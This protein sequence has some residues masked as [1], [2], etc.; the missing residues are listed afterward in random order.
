M[1]IL[2]LGLS[3][4]TATLDLREKFAIPEP[5][6]GAVAA[7]LARAPGL[8]EAVI[9]STCNRVE[10]YVGAEDADRA[11][12]L[13]WAS[14]VAARAGAVIRR[15]CPLPEAWAAASIIRHLF[16]VVCGLD[17][18]VLGETEILG[19]VKKA[20][21]TAQ[22][23]GATAR[24]LNKLFQRAFNVAKEVRTKTNIT[25]GSVSVGSVVAV[26][27]AAKIFGKLA[28]CRVMILG[29]GETS[30]LTAGALARAGRQID[31]RGQ[32]FLRS[33]GRSRGKNGR[34]SGSF[35]RM[36]RQEFHGRGTILI[37]LHGRP[38]TTSLPAKSSRP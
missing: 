37:E 27:L 38:A 35:R 22:E 30:E 23:G 14:F 15:R 31:L 19:Q 17:S 9:V 8:G 7:E 6:L 4:H 29:A 25:R 21:Q 18:M 20:Y 12:S 3:H 5:Q 34:Q 24:H 36:A 1:E 28:E 26:D 13:P 11:V 2:C 32:S 33:G 16:R 10:F